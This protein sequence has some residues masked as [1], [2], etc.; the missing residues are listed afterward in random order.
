M[1]NQYTFCLIKASLIP[2]SR[3]SELKRE[4]NQK[5]RQKHPELDPSLTLSQIRRMKELMV[6]VAMAEV[7]LRV[8]LIARISSSQVWPRRTHS[9]K[10][11]F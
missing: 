7:S 5:F 2:Y 11:S 6:E 8:V 10:S 9:L 1:V 3:P 4:L